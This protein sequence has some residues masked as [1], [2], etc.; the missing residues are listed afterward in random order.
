[1]KITDD[2]KRIEITRMFYSNLQKAPA[3]K[4]EDEE[5]SQNGRSEFS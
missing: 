2:N 1:M 4:N 3:T 5:I